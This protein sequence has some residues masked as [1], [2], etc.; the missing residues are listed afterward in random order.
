MAH[1]NKKFHDQ[2]KALGT[3]VIVGHELGTF[4]VQRWM[5]TDKNG[6]PVERFDGLDKTGNPLERLNGNG[7]LNDPATVTYIPIDKQ[8]ELYCGDTQSEVLG[9]IQA[10]TPDYTKQKGNFYVKN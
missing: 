8:R 2:Q 10:K 5:A 6:K 7:G 3:T 9:K 1:K 4:L